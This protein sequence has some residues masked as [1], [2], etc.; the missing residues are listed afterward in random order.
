[1]SLSLRHKRLLY[2]ATHRGTKEADLLLGGYVKHHILN[3]SEEELEALEVL[4]NLDD[5]TIM[6][7]IRHPLFSTS[8]LVKIRAF[9]KERNF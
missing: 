2:Q 4:L 7:S 5:E 8:L 3:L 6:S 9:Q 1:M